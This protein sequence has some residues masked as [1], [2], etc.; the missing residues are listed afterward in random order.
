MIWPGPADL[1]VIADT[2]L[3]LGTADPLDLL[4]LAA[5]EAAL[6][7]AQPAGAD[8]DPAVCA[9]ALLHA[10]LRHHPFHHGHRQIAVVATLQF[11]ILNGW[12][13]DLGPAQA[14]KAIIAELASGSLTVTDFAAW[15]AP[16]LSPHHEPRTQENSMR[17]RPGQRRTGRPTFKRFTDRA[18]QVVVLA[19]DEARRLSHNYIGTE[20]ILL[21]LVA[22]RE[23]VAA[24]VLESMGI[25]LGAVR[26]HVEE[27]I[28][29]GRQAPAGHIPFTP[30]AKKALELSLREALRLGHNDI[31][32]EHILLSLLREG[33]GVAAQVLI[34]LGASYDQVRDAVL[35]QLAGYKTARGE[36]A[37]APGLGDYDEKI[38]VV[39]H[40]KDAAIDAHDYEL[41]TALRDREKQL[42]AERTRR[43]ADWSAGVDV[44]ALGEELDRLRSE[45]AR[46]QDLLCRRGIQPGDEGARTA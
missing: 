5:A 7:E 14:A 42:L 3:G 33:N 15:L 36:P 41:A 20:H 4:D 23:G 6:A 24:K 45:V 28:G 29:Q 38:A 22:E 11:L 19:Q 39:R 30:R 10:L 12:Q 2:T 18:R 34:K 9:A 35:E 21:G 13:A 17:W 8:P 37:P 40:Q 25:G 43:I 1:A 27:I 31:G 26:L 32:T 16:R 44:V 46:L